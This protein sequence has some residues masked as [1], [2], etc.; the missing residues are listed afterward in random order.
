MIIQGRYGVALTFRA[1]IVKAGSQ[2]LAA[3]ADWT[4]ATGDVKISK[5]GGAFANITTLP[6]ALGSHWVWALSAT[7]MEAKEIVVQTVDSATKAVEDQSFRITTVPGGAITAGK[8]QAGS[9]STVQLASGE[10]FGAD[11]RIRGY[12]VEIHGGTGAGQTRS[13]LS[14]VNST[15]TLTVDRDFDTAP[16]SGSYYTLWPAPPGPTA[17]ANLP[18]VKVA[19]QSGNLGIKK[20]TALAN[21]MFQ[22]TDSTNHAPATGLT[23]SCFRSLDGGTFAATATAT[24]TEVANGWYKIN[25]AA[26]DT[27]GD[28]V[29]FRATAS[30]ADDTNLSFI[31]GT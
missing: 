6:T 21:F 17:T 7:E 25:L 28:V 20:N 15:D 16:D 10:D 27:N 9:T 5:D 23:V 31:T 18:L 2:D 14:S 22:M 30:G 26:A 29:A 24:A 13:V 11:N 3:T 4:P 19:A 12:V 8:C 1:P